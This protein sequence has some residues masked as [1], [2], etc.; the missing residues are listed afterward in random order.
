MCEMR[1]RLAECGFS[2]ETHSRACE[3]AATPSESCRCSCGG[4]LHGIACKSKKKQ[5]TL[6]G[7][8]K[9]GRHT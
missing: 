7:G 9:D 2:V 5:V 4:R 8:D 1:E 3:L 6:L